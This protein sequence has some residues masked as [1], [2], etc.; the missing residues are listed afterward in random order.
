VVGWLHEL[1]Y[2]AGADL[3]FSSGGVATVFSIADER[4]EQ[5]LTQ[6][7]LAW[8]VITWE[9]HVSVCKEWESQYGCGSKHG[10]RNKHGAKAQFEYSNRSAEAFLIV[11]FLGNIG[12]EY[13]ISKRGPRKAA[14]ECHGDG[15]L[16]DLSA[17]AD[18]DFFIVPVDFS[19][20]MIH[21][22]EDYETSGPIFIYKDWLRQPL[23]GQSS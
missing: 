13:S 10:L 22:H 16:P 11:P 20:T 14:Y 19:W 7:G 8:S 9:Q 15:V 6:C 21:T 3:Q 2:L 1:I 12:G 5:V 4:L 18:T 23:K 17:F